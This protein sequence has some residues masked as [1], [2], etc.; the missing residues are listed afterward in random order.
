MTFPKRVGDMEVATIPAGNGSSDRR[1]GLIR[2]SATGLTTAGAA[3][4]ECR[5]A[6]R[7]QGG[8]LHQSRANLEPK[9]RKP[10]CMKTSK[11]TPAD[12]RLAGEKPPFSKQ[13]QIEP[14]GLTSEMEP[15]PDHGE[16]SYRGNGLLRD[17]ATII[18]G[19]DSGIG[20]A[21]ALAFAREGADVVISY[22]ECEEEDAVGTERLVTDAGRRALCIPGDIR[23][24]KH[25][26]KIIEEC[27][28]T[29]G[30]LDVL[31]NNAAYQ[32]THSNAEE[33][34]TEEFDRAFKTNVYATF[35][36]SRAALR[37]MKPGA[38]IINST[39]IQGYDPSGH[40]LHYAA[41]KAAIANMTRTFAEL[42]SEKG[43]RVNG[44]APGPVWT[45][46]IPSTMDAKK[47]K[48]FGQ[49]SF[50]KRPAQPAE[51]A[52]VYVFLASR[53]ASF[54]TGEIYGVTGGRMPL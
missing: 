4:T 12:P 13:K 42:C 21:V 17:C 30:K 9:K 18:T 11:A 35:F 19:A 2:G 8:R 15:Q 54:V 28:A 25:C 26:E 10:Q 36:L 41:T 40:L 27:V 46:L 43:I 22:L 38:S 7:L 23:R 29:F 31:V 34:S 32:S 5:A 24:E 6:R 50:F 44:V 33:I 39:S 45:P 51:L 16:K 3:G 52:P 48:T 37:H 53:A 20:R 49:D 1:G 47:V 14:P